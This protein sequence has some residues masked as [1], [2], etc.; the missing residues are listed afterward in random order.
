[1]AIEKV[2]REAGGRPVVLA[3][4][5]YRCKHCRNLM[6]FLEE[7]CQA[8]PDVIFKKMDVNASQDLAYEFGVTSVPICFLYLNGVLCYQVM[9][10]NKAL[11]M[12]NITELRNRN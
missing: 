1:S 6:P 7:K 2:L 11:L 8:M 5:S 12:D 10:D 9:G 4:L 3:C